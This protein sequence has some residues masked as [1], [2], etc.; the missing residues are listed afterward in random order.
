[1]SQVF[2][3]QFLEQL[4]A[5]D[6]VNAALTAARDDIDAVLWR[7]DIRAAA[8]EVAAASSERGARA[9]AT[10]DG[11][12]VVV[13]DDS[14]MGR[15]LGSARMLTEAV[16]GQVD[17]WGKA[18]LQV[19][20]HLHA[21]ASTGFEPAETLGRPRATDEAD[22]PLRIGQLPATS[23]LAPGLM[24]LSSLVTRRADL[25]GLL[26]AALVHHEIL[27]LRPFAWGSGLVGRALVRCV[28]ADR[29]LDP[30][31]FTIPEHG[32][33]ESGRPAYVQAIRNYGTGTIDGV[34][35]SVLW[36]ATACAMGAAAVTV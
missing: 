34:A 36:F 11:A 23:A 31:L 21:L 16:P 18:P 26:T 28:L 8:N 10:I 2:Q 27:W 22:D 13:V 20:A 3:P 9:S 7:R 12:D 29:G 17:T 15:V 14:P 19:I 32:F 1:M 6:D 30:S 25:P 33:V 35:E 5:R 4:L 24:A